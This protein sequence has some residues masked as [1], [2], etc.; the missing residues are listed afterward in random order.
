[1]KRYLYILLLAIL[2]LTIFSSCDDNDVPDVMVKVK[3]GD[4]YRIGNVLYVVQGDNLEVESVRI[5]NYGTE[6]DVL[7]SVAYF[8]DNTRVGTAVEAP[9]GCVFD[10]AYAPVG[11]HLLQLSASVFVT[12]FS[13][14]QATVTYTVVIVPG[15]EDIPDG[16]IPAPEVDAAIRTAQN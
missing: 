7:G 4:C 11:E 16:A 15:L 12:N 8:W 13:P 3:M 14:S 1:M 9:Y 5:E 10:T 6:A 2:P